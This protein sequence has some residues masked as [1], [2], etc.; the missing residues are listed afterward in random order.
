MATSK[1]SEKKPP[2]KFQD[3]QSPK[4]PKG[5]TTK[6]DTAKNSISNVR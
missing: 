1:K 5:G 4:N 6:H 3:L 2:V